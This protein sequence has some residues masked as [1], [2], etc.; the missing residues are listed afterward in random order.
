MKLDDKLQHPSAATFKGSSGNIPLAWSITFLVLSGLFIALFLYH[1]FILPYPKS[2][3]EQVRK[4]G[5]EV[6]RAF[7]DTFKS[8]FTKPNIGIAIAFMLLYR[9]GEA[10]LVKMVTPFML[11]GRELGG[12]GLTTGQVGIAYGTVGVM[13]LTLGGILGGILT[14]RRGLHCWM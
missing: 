5:S 11:D 2:D 7:G 3:N 6:L 12:L 14:S 9:L 1:R 10:M 4:S 8:F 13:A